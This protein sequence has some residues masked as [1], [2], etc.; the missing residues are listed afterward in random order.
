MDD[1]CHFI[2]DEISCRVA[3]G[4]EA[5]LVD[6]IHMCKYA[7]QRSKIHSHLSYPIN[8][9]KCKPFSK[10]PYFSWGILFGII[11]NIYMIL[12]H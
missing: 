12:L 4:R 5:M 6:A 9:K 8:N 3:L 1:Y 7:R 2:S 11:Y 10:L